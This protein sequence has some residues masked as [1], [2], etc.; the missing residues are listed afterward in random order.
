VSLIVKWFR[1]ATRAALIADKLVAP[2]TPSYVMRDPHVFMKDDG[3]GADLMLVRAISGDPK[4]AKSTDA[5][6]PDG[7][8][9]HQR[10]P[11]ASLIFRRLTTG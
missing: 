11:S 4:S 1:K 9:R 6:E 5:D 8:D 7:Q 10:R 3:T 2:T